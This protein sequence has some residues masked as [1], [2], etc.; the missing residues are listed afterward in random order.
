M[1]TN[2]LN[3]EQ[4]HT[5][6]LLSEYS[7]N[8]NAKP[9]QIIKARVCGTYASQVIMDAG[10]KSEAHIP[11]QQFE[12]EEEKLEIGQE[13]AVYLISLDNGKGEVILSREKARLLE[14]LDQLE[15]DMAST[16]II[17]GKIT[18]IVRGGYTVLI[19]GIKAFLPGSLA[20]FRDPVEMIN[21]TVELRVLRVNRERQ[22]VVVS[23]KAVVEEKN[24][25]EKDRLINALK[26]GD[27]IKGTI[28]NITHFGAFVDT[29][30]LDGL[31]HIADISWKRI[32]HPSDVLAIG[33]KVEAKVL[34]IENNKLF[35]GL[36]QI[37]HDPWDNLTEEIKVGEIYEGIINNITDYGCFV[38][39]KE[40]VEGLV[41][42]S[43]VDWRMKTINPHKYFK[44]GD[45]IKVKVTFI[46][47]DRRRIALSVK[48]CQPN[49][50]ESFAEKYK[51]YDVLSGKISSV[52][53]F[54]VFVRLEEGIDGLIHISEIS[55]RNN[56]QPIFSQYRVG[57]DIEVVILS[58][59][60]AKQRLGLGLLQISQEKFN[61]FTKNHEIGSKVS[62]RVVQVE[63]SIAKIELEKGII[64]VLEQ[65]KVQEMITYQENDEV[66][67]YISGFN[68]KDRVIILSLENKVT[69][70]KQQS[71]NYATSNNKTT[72]GNLI[73]DK[74]EEDA[75]LRQKEEQEKED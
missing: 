54:G 11:I 57:D 14:A 23:R 17:V 74:I 69:T 45:S 15:L 25:L 36:K 46:D 5:M 12:N 22:N 51:K 70:K 16:A 39:L 58:I 6:L 71:R 53:E 41:H 47:L 1:T 24:Q 38:L 9:G 32:Q 8:I 63:G 44:L 35:L 75:A 65:D 62:G 73:K 3:D 59:D 72:L 64:A 29:G 52:T 30:V 61:T 20:D 37:T 43:A 34:N 31:I 68:K 28:K 55:A 27:I 48:A 67:A 18:R 2:V 66:S 56:P 50:W 33:D 42:C 26:P 19:R 13:I 4:Q 10:L 49:P 60:I 7:P 21:T 40:G